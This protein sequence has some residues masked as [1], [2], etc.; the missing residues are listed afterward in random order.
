MGKGEFEEVQCAWRENL[1]SHWSRT[2]RSWDAE[3][4]VALLP[5]GYWEWLGFWQWLPRV[6][7]VERGNI[8]PRGVQK[9]KWW[10]PRCH[11]CVETCVSPAAC[12]IVRRD[13]IDWKGRKRKK[14]KRKQVKISKGIK[15]M[16]SVPSALALQRAVC[17]WTP[18][19][20][21]LTDTLTGPKASDA[22]PTPSANLLPAPGT[23]SQVPERQRHRE[24]TAWA[25]APPSGIQKKGL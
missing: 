25:I 8:S 19:T 2:G 10:L 3:K 17:S 7:E 22:K 24:T 13:L 12:R 4:R 9:P 6:E 21:P 23:H 11:S 18:G 14:K 20:A 5:Q 1:V 16:H 15:G